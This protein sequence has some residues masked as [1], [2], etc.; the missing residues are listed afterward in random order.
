[1]YSRGVF[2]SSTSTEWEPPFTFNWYAAIFYSLGTREPMMSEREFEK[3]PRSY[4][5]PV[6]A[7]SRMEASLQRNKHGRGGHAVHR[8]GHGLI[9]GSEPGGNRHIELERSG[10]PDAREARREG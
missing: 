3:T 4:V 5:C 7:S 2:G 10:K 8:R 6:A 9:A 1:M